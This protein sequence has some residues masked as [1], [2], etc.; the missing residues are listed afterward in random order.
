MKVW[1]LIIF[2]AIIGVLQV[3][4]L[5][6]FKVFGVK[7]DILLIAVFMAG[8]FL[9]LR[10]ALNVGLLAGIF[11][12]AFSLTPPGVNTI[13]FPMWIFLIAKLIHEVSIDDNLTRMLLLFVVVLLNNIISGLVLI[14]SGGFLPLGIFLRITL[15]ASIYTALILPLIL[16][17]IVPTP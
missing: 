9:D 5:D 16:R 14:Y 11:K 2:T 12:D 8:I 4:L 10:P 3:T 7:P 13:L 17:F 15:L 6:C 1:R